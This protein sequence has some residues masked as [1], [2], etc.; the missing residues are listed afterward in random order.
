M[1]RALFNVRALVSEVQSHGRSSCFLNF[2]KKFDEKVWMVPSVKKGTPRP[3]EGD[4]ELP[5][6]TIQIVR[7]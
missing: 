3:H 4:M 7:M 6:P 2:V 1:V 5:L